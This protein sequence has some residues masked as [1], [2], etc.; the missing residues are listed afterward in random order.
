MD[1]TLGSLDPLEACR[2][3][4]D[5]MKVSLQEDGFQCSS[6]SGVSESR[7]MKYMLSS[8]LWTCL[9]FLEDN[10]ARAIGYNL[11]ICWTVLGKNSVKGFSCLVLVFMLGGFWL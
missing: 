9:S 7:L 10:R 8:T 11:G 6:N 3:P 5:P 4:F 2:V 1:A